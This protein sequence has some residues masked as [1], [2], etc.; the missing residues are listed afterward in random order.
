M[1]TT[2]SPRC[3]SP[4]PR[5]PATACWPRASPPPTST[6]PATPSSTRC[7][8]TVRPDY[9][10]PHAGARRARPGAPAG[11]GHDPP[12][13]ELR[14]AAASPPARPSA[15]WSSRFPDIA[16]RPAGASQSHRSRRPS[17]RRSATS[18]RVHLIEPVDYVEFV[19]LMTRAHL[20][21]TDSGG[22]QE[23]AP[24]AGQA[25][26]GPPR[27]DRAARGRGRGHRG[28]GR[29]RPRPDRESLASE[30]LVL[31]AAYERMA[32][33]V[34]PYGDGHASE[35]IVAALAERFG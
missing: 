19:H 3:T 15:D 1:L 10:L 12:P 18:P 7:S 32:N 4:R 26:A 25:G 29:H 33:A 16:G 8:Q 5:R 28:R 13:R 34:N 30:L 35:R 17:R 22:V 2:R 6:S 21:L 11:A 31:A 23:E 9:R 24:F 14:R 27:G 20:M